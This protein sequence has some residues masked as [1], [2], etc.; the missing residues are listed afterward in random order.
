MK[1][2]RKRGKKWSGKGIE[3]GKIRQKEPERP[4]KYKEK[5]RKREK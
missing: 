1:W 2:K 4:K 3:R 5:E